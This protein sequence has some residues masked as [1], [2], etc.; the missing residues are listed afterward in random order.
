MLRQRLALVI[1]LT[2]LAAAKASAGDPNATDPWNR[3]WTDWHRNNCWMEPFVYPDRSSVGNFM[4]AQIAKGWQL[5]C[6]LGDPHFESDNS[7]LSPAGLMKLHMILQNPGLSHP[8]F[9][10]RSWDEGATSKR[11]AVVQQAVSNLSRGPAPEVLVSNMPL[12]SAPADYVNNVNNWLTGYMHGIPKIQPRA[13]TTDDS[14][15]S[16][17]K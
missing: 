14:S 7:K 15:S 5:Q 16:S 12:N 4:D 2:L 17:S 3:F 11:L 9:V 6:L 13:F 8:V 1:T 10:E